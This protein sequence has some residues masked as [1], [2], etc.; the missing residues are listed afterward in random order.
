MRKTALAFLLALSTTAAQAADIVMHSSE[1]C[2]CC[3]VWADRMRDAGHEVR[4]IKEANLGAFKAERGIPMQLAS[5]HTAIVDGYVIEGHVPASDIQRLLAERPDA[6]GLFV[7]GM[8][9]GSPG[10][11][12]GNRTQPYAV[13]LLEKDGTA[14]IWSRHGFG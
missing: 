9:I 7:P 4:V 8:P 6:V 3:L 12:Q 13:I 14:S 10:M 2:G 11:E 1:G 5:C